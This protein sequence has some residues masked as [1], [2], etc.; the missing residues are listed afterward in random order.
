MLNS[1]GRDKTSSEVVLAQEI[2]VL[3][4]LKGGAKCLTF[5]KKGGGG[6]TPN[7]TLSERGRGCNKFRTPIFHFVSPPLP[8]IIM[9]I[10]Y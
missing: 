2:E 1:N 3:A 5:E 6:G 4:I 7:C 8:I 10:N 9:V